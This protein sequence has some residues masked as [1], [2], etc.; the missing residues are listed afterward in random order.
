MY[1]L[2]VCEGVIVGWT[3]EVTSKVTIGVTAETLEKI[4]TSIPESLEVWQTSVNDDLVVYEKGSV[5]QYSNM[6]GYFITEELNK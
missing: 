1:F 6:V 2:G 5:H 4:V 3:T